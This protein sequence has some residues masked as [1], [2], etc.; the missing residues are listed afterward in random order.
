MSIES[1]FHEEDEGDW[2]LREDRLVFNEAYEEPLTCR[3]I[4][5]GV[6]ALSEMPRGF[7]CL[8]PETHQLLARKGGRA[9]QKEPEARRW[10]LGD[11]AASEAGRKG[12]RATQA[13][14]RVCANSC[15]FEIFRLAPGSQGMHWNPTGHIV[16]ALT[17]REARRLGRAALGPGT[18]KAH[19]SSPEIRA[20]QAKH[21]E[22]ITSKLAAGGA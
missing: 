18:Y 19:V 20:E 22:E 1:P 17:K 13:Q 11:S 7:A 6:Y 10:K 15:E 9:V 2:Q 4:E 3:L 16:V 5:V 14:A 8:L 21:A 12:G